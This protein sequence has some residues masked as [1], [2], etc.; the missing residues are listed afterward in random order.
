MKA[1]KSFTDVPGMVFKI[2]S[3]GKAVVVVVEFGGTTGIGRTLPV[4]S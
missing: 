1:R 4:L 3:V 2:H